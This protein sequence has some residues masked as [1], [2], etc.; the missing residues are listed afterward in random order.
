MWTYTGTIAFTAPEV[1]MDQEYTES[2]DMWSAGVVL[3]TM[4]CGYQPF[5]ADYVNDLIELIK[6]GKYEFHADPWDNISDLAKDLIRHLLD[7][8]YKT[9]YSPSQ[10]L[11]HPWI[12]NQGK[13]PNKRIHTIQDNM[14]KNSKKII[15]NDSDLLLSRV[16]SHLEL[17]EEGEEDAVDEIVDSIQFRKR[18]SE[19]VKICK[20]EDY[21]AKINEIEEIV[22]SNMNTKKPIVLTNEELTEVSA[23][24]EDSPYVR[25]SRNERAVSFKIELRDLNEDN[26]YQN[27]L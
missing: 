11:M 12:S 16:P 18:R 27:S 1:F 20:R 24:E 6:A 15:A 10:A 9:R 23:L 8:N 17:D 19:T 14:R 13:V 21:L 26:I 3:Y 5:Q 7:V 2:V 4:L 22:K 25:H